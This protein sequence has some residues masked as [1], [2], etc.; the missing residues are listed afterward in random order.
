[1]ESGEGQGYKWDAGIAERQEWNEEG[2]TAISFPDKT[3]Y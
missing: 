2:E 1:M 3:K